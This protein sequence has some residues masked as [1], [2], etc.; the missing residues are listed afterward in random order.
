MKPCEFSIYHFHKGYCF[1]TRNGTYFIHNCVK[2]NDDNQKN[3]EMY[4][5]KL[6]DGKALPEWIQV[7]PET[8]ETTA[9]IPEGIQEVEVQLVALDKDGNK[10]D[11]NI[12]LDKANIKNDQ[13]FTR[14]TVGETQVVVDNDGGHGA[15]G[16]NPDGSAFFTKPGLYPIEVAWFN[17][18][19]T[20]D[21]GD[22][23]GANIDLTINGEP[24][25]ETK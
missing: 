11:I 18:N 16:P 22:H 17:G 8:G 23:G 4:S 12:V 7:N 19:W 24:L 3:V 25:K 9:N 13:D 21:S 1:C 6:S 2:L 5:G 15:P 14:G 10:R 20:N